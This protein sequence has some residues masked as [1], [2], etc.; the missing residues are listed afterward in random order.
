MYAGER[1]NSITHLVGAVL[2]LIGV[3][4]MITLA[5]TEGGAVRISSLTI[6]GVTLF[7]LYLFSTLYHSLRGRAK[8]IFRMLDHHAIYL[9][10][11][12]TYTPFTLLALQ[13]SVGWWLFSAVWGLAVIGMILESLPRKGARVLPILI[14]LAMGWLVVF[15]LDPLIA[16]LPAAGFWWLLAGGLFY[17]VGVIFYVLDDRFPWCHGIWHLFVLAGSISHYFTILLYL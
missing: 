15:A 14:Y 6:Y 13:G 3:T 17:T 4:V 12:G 9:L 7:L 16:A 11:A 10:I 5:S 1:F 8:Q 2:A